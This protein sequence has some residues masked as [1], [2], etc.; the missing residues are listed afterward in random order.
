MRPDERLKIAKFHP[1]VVQKVGK[2]VFLKKFCF[3]N[4]P[5]KSLI[6]LGNFK[7][8]FLSRTFLKI[9][10]SGHTADES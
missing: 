4:L 3:S 10:Q 5:I 6:V 1:N 7:K 2:A 8:I 9:A